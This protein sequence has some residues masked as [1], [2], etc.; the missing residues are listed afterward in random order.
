MCD[1]AELCF[2]ALDGHVAGILFEVVLLIYCFIALAIIC[3]KYL[4]LSLETLCVRWNIREDVAGA[5]IMAF[6]SA[7]PEIIINTIGTMR[8]GD[9][10]DLG[11]GA[12]IGSGMVAF[13]V[14]LGFC[15]LVA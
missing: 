6:G 14:I 2:D 12:I 1:P 8:G 13:L 9:N 5:S 10:A 15:G 3:D 11:V 4:V 7:A